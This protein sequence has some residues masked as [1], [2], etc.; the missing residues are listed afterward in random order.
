MAPMRWCP[1]SA[2]LTRSRLGYTMAASS[3]TSVEA[4][5]DEGDEI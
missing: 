4:V 2:Q 3:E 1:R 5:V